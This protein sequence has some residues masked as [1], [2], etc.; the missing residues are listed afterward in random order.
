MVPKPG[1]ICDPDTGRCVCP[2]RTRGDRCERCEPGAWD[3]HA[4]KGCKVR[5]R[6]QVRLRSD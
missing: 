4:F 6:E 5:N 3:Y 2:P 1:H